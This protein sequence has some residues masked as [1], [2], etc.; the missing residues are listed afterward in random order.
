[1][2]PP[3][4]FAHTDHRAYLEAWY[5]WRKAKNPRFSYRALSRRLGSNDPSAVLNVVRGRRGL[6]DDRVEQLVEILELDEPQAVYFRALVRAGQAVD[7]EDVERTRAVVAELRSRH[8]QRRVEAATLLA[9]R[10]WPTVL[11]LAECEGFRPEPAWVAAALEPPISEEK[12][13]EALRVLAELGLLGP[14]DDRTLATDER[15]DD[16]ASQ[17]YHR[18]NTALAARWIDRLEDP[19]VAERCSFL[20]ATVAVPEERLADLGHLLWE[21]QQR[22][23]HQISTW[24]GP[25]DRVVQITL[26][27][28]P[29]SRRVG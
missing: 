27:A 5:R 25:R 2:Q 12:A 4:P 28:F 6:T 15:V 16:L 23:L 13:A 1:M 21:L 22:L 10:C 20:G 24:E 14:G 26:Q 29:A 7:P 17:P 8:R 18:Q 19:E 9:D 3:D 11:T